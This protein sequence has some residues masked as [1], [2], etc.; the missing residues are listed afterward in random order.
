VNETSIVIADGMPI[1]L[2][3]LRTLLEAEHGIRIAA[4]TTDGLDV[5][6]LLE[7]HM[8]NVL[9][10]DLM[11]PNLGGL[12]ILRQSRQRV[13]DTKVIILSSSTTEDYLLEALRTGVAGFLIK[14]FSLAELTRAVSE[15]AC[16][17]HYLSSI[18]SEWALEAYIE[19]AVA[20]PAIE[21]ESLTNRE[22]EVLRLAADGKSNGQ[23]ADRLS[24]S[25]R[26]AETH[27]GNLM[28]K[29]ALRNQTDLIRFALRRGIVASED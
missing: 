26:T 17:K 4:E 27:R 16:G 11:M 24:I 22:R 10:V 20:R 19:K 1:V 8:P 25:V 3:G 23:I 29:L 15:V 9:I 13:P 7:R 28:R 12:D 14:D 18:L 6:M 21:Y 5:V 2:Y